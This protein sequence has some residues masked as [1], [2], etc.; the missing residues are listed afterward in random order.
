[1]HSQAFVAVVRARRVEATLGAEQRRD[2]ALIK[3]DQQH[4]EARDHLPGGH[5]SERGADANAHVVGAREEPQV[6]GE[7][8]REASS[9]PRSINTGNERS[10]KATLSKAWLHWWPARSSVLISHRTSGVIETNDAP[11]ATIS[12]STACRAPCS[13]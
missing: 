6:A 8:G 9:L 1:M 5:R 10:A 3:T 11:V 7:P 2:G 13:I 12:A 4:E